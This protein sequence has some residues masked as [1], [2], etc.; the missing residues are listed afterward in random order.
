[1]IQRVQ[2]IYLFLTALL[3]GLSAILTLAYYKSGTIDVF[4]FK[5]YQI[6]DID[7]GQITIP[8]NVYLQ[9]G[10]IAISLLLALFA[11]SRYKNRKLQLKLG[12]FNFLL[13]IALVL[14]TYFGVKNLL[15]LS[16]LNDFENLQPVYWFGFYS[17]V[18]A[19]A[20]QFLAN[21]GIKKDEKLVRSVERLR[22]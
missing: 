11:I 10:L 9:L 19:L 5:V 13:L 2:T 15:N 8:G 21:R 3:T 1:M 22:G 6:T 16:P 7:S 18:A 4:E 12:Q 20:F 14:S 17:P